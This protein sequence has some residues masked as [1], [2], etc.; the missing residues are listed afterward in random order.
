M[1]AE[2]R[3]NPGDWFDGLTP[4]GTFSYIPSPGSGYSPYSPAWCMPNCDST[5]FPGS[6]G[7]SP[8]VNVVGSAHAAGFNALFCDGSVHLL[9]Y[10]IDLPLLYRLGCRDDGEPVDLNKL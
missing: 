5:P 8:W 6:S 4:Y 2:K 1:I 10:G 3:I 9:H 7:L